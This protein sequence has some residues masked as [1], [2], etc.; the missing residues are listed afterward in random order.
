MSLYCMGKQPISLK[1][2]KNFNIVTGGKG[3]LTQHGAAVAV[4]QFQPHTG[5]ADVPAVLKDC[6]TYSRTSIGNAENK[7]RL[8]SQGQARKVI[9]MTT[10]K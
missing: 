2:K 7:R 4:G 1:G 3:K 9:N 10:E 8:D 5:S 6:F